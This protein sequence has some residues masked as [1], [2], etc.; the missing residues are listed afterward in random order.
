MKSI[1]SLFAVSYSKIFKVGLLSLAVIS[2]VHAETTD[3]TKSKDLEPTPSLQTTMKSTDTLTA[4]STLSAKEQLVTRLSKI[5]TLASDFTQ[6]VLDEEGTLL[7]EG[8]GNLLIQKPNKVR[9]H[10]QSPEESLIISDGETLWFY[11]PFIEQ[12]SAHNLTDAIAN[13]PIMMLTSNDEKIWNDYNI[14]QSGELSFVIV[15]KDANSQ[16]K[17]LA[18]DFSEAGLSAFTISDSTGQQSI[19]TLKNIAEGAT[20]DAKLFSFEIPEGV[21]LDDQR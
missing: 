14:S 2:S 11:D 9:W 16:V 20:P 6:K 7:Q 17:S 13:T 18:I 3:G 4:E 15:A 10:T 21:Y 19:I 12:V 5:S 1:N 8:S